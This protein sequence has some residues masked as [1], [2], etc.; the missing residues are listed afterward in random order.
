MKLDAAEANLEAECGRMQRVVLTAVAL[1]V[2]AVGAPWALNAEYPFGD[3]NSAHFA[4]A[5]H[6]ATLIEHA[7][8]N[9]WWHHSNLGLPL[10]TAYH[11]LPALSMGAIIAILGNAID[12]VVLFKLSILVCW[13]LMPAAWA[14]GGRLLGMKPSAAVV[15]GILTLA[16]HDPDSIGFGVRSSVFRGLYTQHFGLLL[17][18]IAVG[19]VWTAM[20]GRSRFAFRSAVL[21]GALLMSHLWVGLY[22]AICIAVLAV[23]EPSLAA[24]RIRRL[25]PIAGVAFCLVSPWLVPLLMTNEYAGGLPWRRQLHE[26]WPWQDIVSRL[27]SGQIFDYG[28][29][30]W[31]TA[32]VMGGAA[33][34]LVHVRNPLA[35]RW[36]LLTAA[37]G[38]LFLGRTN[39]GSAYD[40]LPLHSQVNVMRYITGVHICGLLAAS[41][42]G[43]TVLGVARRA[44]GPR[45]AQVGFGVLLMGVLGAVYADLKGTLKTFDAQ[46]S[47]YRELVDAV[48][49]G[50]D[51]RFAVHEA[52]GTGSHF[53]RDLLP[54]LANRGQLQSYAHGYH[55]TLST[56][57]AEYFDFSP[58]AAE[59]FGVGTV[60]AKHPVP[61]DFPLDVWPE[62]WRNKSYSVHELVNS[63]AAELVSFVDV[64]GTIEGPSFRSLR[65]IIKRL[66]VPAF[67]LGIVPEVAM[68]PSIETAVVVDGSGQRRDWRGANAV[69]AVFAGERGS[70]GSL[71]EILTVSRGLSSYAARVRS[72]GGSAHLMLKVNAFPWWS[73]RVDGVEVPIRHVAPNFMAVAVPSGEHVVR[74]EYTNPWWQK[75]GAVISVV[76]G[77]FCIVGRSSFGGRAI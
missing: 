28:R 70:D 26:G 35:R 27:L 58:A 10:F 1:C 72:V 62:V 15:L 39:L 69:D 61:D 25:I 48:R 71:G 17:L 21:F 13:M 57:Y 30:M 20:E 16:V 49:D 42:I 4:V 31:L 59:V 55:C 33:L 12:P 5:M 22:G 24:R 34:T 60:V 50:P 29:P 68:D 76:V 3:D 8:T 38:T 73:A 53:H 23:A 74:W 56:Y 63:D 65:P 47:A 32:C 36:M 45:I 9:A 43:P 2:F 40:L 52:L 51:R 75:L 19:H 46:N 54:L 77:F 37:T 6:I 44:G 7:E 67:A 14:L 66:A 64:R 11:P 41:A 18:P